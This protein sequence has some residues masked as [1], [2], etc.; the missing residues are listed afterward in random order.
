[1]NR[2]SAKLLFQWRVT[3][4][5]TSGQRRTCEERIIVLKADSAAQALAKAKR[6]GRDGQFDYT[7][8]DGNPV[9]FQFI[10]IME[11]LKLD[12]V[13]EEDEVWFEVKERLLPMERA[14]K[15]IPPEH[16]LEAIRNEPR[17]KKVRQ[18]KRGN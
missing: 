2:Y 15:F 9:E 18:I 16:L 1:M 13:C 12:P 3:S 11:L 4:G 14:E 8:S 5:G 17:R 6:K 7:S 10:G